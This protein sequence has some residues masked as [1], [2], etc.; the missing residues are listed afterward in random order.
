MNEKKTKMMHKYRIYRLNAMAC[1]VEEDE[2]NLS[3]IQLELTTD[4]FLLLGKRLINK[5]TIDTI[6]EVTD[7]E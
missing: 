4:S 3:E 6:V 7:V 2:K 1:E 5:A